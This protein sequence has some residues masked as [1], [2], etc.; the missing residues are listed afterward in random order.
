MDVIAKVLGDRLHGG[1]QAAQVDWNVLSLQD[2][3][4]AVIEQRIAVIVGD[5]EDAGARGFFQRQGH[6]TLGC[7]QRT[8][9]HSQRNRVNFRRDC[10]QFLLGASRANAAP[11]MG[12]LN[13]LKRSSV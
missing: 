2:H 5:V 3:F 12:R 9:H 6:F 4:G 13:R 10:H 11:S 8:T 7:F 1:H